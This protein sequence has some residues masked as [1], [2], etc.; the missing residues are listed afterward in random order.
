MG[1]G[2]CSRRRSGI[3]IRCEVKAGLGEGDASCVPVL[4]PVFVPLALFRGK[5][6]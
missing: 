2:W 1:D 6:D 4:F 3:G 5:C